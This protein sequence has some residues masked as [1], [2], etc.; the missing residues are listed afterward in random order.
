M[1]LL[2]LGRRVEL[3]NDSSPEVLVLGY[4]GEPY[5]R[6]GPSG[7]WVNRRSPASYLN[8]A[9]PQGSPTTTLPPHADPR[10]APEWHRLSGT[11][12][13]R[14]RDRRTRW[15]SATP[16]SV[17]ASPGRVQPVG[18]FVLEMRQGAVPTV[19]SGSIT[20]VPP[21]LWWP[22]VLGAVGLAIAVAALAR[23]ARWHLALA[24]ALAVLVPLDA[25]HSFGIAAAATT[26][27]PPW[28]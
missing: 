11:H 6:V 20:W 26:R 18:R 1:R 8:Q 27:S 10:A 15:G 12:R 17:K 19:V 13:A 5:L 7:V 4:Q 9:V 23:T 21:P 16:P 22:W 24:A 3:V 14:W 28:R 25:A 2:D